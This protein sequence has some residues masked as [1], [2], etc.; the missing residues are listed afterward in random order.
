MR[1][2]IAR[3]PVVLFL[4]VSTHAGAVIPTPGGPLTLTPIPV[5]V[6]IGDQTNPSVD[7]D[8][9][10]YSA[11]DRNNLQIRY[12]RFSTGVDLAVPNALPGG[13]TAQDYLPHVQDERVVMTRMYPDGHNGIVLY[14]VPSATLVEVDPVPGSS[15][16]GCSIGGN[17]VAYAD[18]G[19]VDP[20]LQNGEIFAWDVLTHAVVRLTNDA[21]YDD[22]PVVAPSGDLIVWES[23]AQPYSDCNVM[24]AQRGP[25]GWVVTPV[26]SSPLNETNP[27]TDGTLI[28]WQADAGDG[29]GTD[30][31]WVRAGSTDVQ[32]LELAR[33]QTNASVAGSVIAFESRAPPG[34]NNNPNNDVF[35]YDIATNRMFQ[36]TD[37]TGF[38]EALS[39]V[40]VLPTGEV[41]VVWQADD[42]LLPVRSN[43]IYA[44]TFRLPPG[45]RTYTDPALFLQDAGAVSRID[46][47]HGVCGDP[48]PFAT[49][50]YPVGAR[51]DPL[52]VTFGG[53]HLRVV[54]Q[55]GTS[56]NVLSNTPGGVA[57]QFEGPVFAAGLSVLNPPGG[58][59]TTGGTTKTASL[60]ALDA[61]GT[62]LAYVAHASPTFL[63]VTSQTAISRVEVRVSGAPE[64]PSVDD[65][66][67]TTIVA[68]ACSAP[69]TTAS[70]TPNPNATGWNRTPVKLEL[71]AIPGSGGSAVTSIAY[72]LSGAVT[73]SQ[74]VPGAAASI[75]LSGEGVTTVS[76]GA[77]DM[78]G[79]VEQA[80]ALTIRI[81][82]T[83]PSLALP[84][85]ITVKA[86]GPSGAAVPYAWTATD[87]LDPS[88]ASS[89]A[90]PSGTTFPPGTASVS[91]I[92]SDVAGNL[93]SASFTVR[94]KGGAEQIQDL[95]AQVREMRLGRIIEP[96]LL[97]TLRAALSSATAGN[98]A[99]AC[100]AM[101]FFE[102]LVRAGGSR[103]PQGATLIGA[104]R[105]ARMALGCR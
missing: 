10:A 26:A 30:I 94:V 102:Q 87:A 47:D 51:Y 63:G 36:I 40:T 32:R 71:A 101:Q 81:D 91:C 39:D 18:V 82:L 90:P 72:S 103:I 13:F 73:A 19:V 12:F 105:D 9:A 5:N 48:L 50:P 11:I 23:C 21:R 43:N 88:P 65:L 24:M 59:S 83:P 55:P 56:T 77:T 35:L 86:T 68:P 57:I 38:N 46:F 3:I 62:V 1:Q 58:A 80:Q 76:F 64:G 60:V 14:D 8:L 22:S 44:A 70:A 69:V 6:G 2:A 29:S 20:V 37:T 27:D 53:A 74:I 34:V 41:R 17:T 97:T 54:A 28:A 79:V 89:C 84:G 92:A 42:E 93:A 85:P 96:V 45:T 61:T 31:Y 7:Q 75:P 4:V 99:L 95:M 78:A 33:Y 67:F 104:S 100:P 98:P 66:L 49:V 52:R 25:S 15:R 16:F